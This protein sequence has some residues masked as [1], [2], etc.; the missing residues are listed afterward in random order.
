MRI[1]L[2]HTLRSIKAHI[3][4]PIVIV[5]TVTVATMLF[6]ASLS[7]KDLFYNFQLA[8]LSRVAQGADVSIEGGLFSGDR[9]DE[10][11][12]EKSSEV[13]Y[14]D[15]YLTSA[16]IISG[17]GDNRESTAI[18]IEATDLN[19]FL[20]RHKSSLHY[21]KGISQADYVYPEIWISRSL[22]EKL[23]C[24]VGGEAEIYVGFY[25]R[26]ETF[27]V[28]YI[29]ENEGF[30]ANSTVHNVLTDLSS[31]GDKGLYTEA[32][33]K[34]KESVDKEGF[35]DALSA[36]MDNAELEIGDAVDY[37]Y[38][39]RVVSDNENLL[40]I[41]LI[42]VVALV[43]FIL[44]GAYGVVAKN[45]AS[46]M[47][48]FKAAGASPLQ[49]FLILIT[50][51]IFYGLA[52]GIAG[53]VC[54]RFG[55]EIVVQSVIPGFSDA[56]NYKV[57]YYVLSVLL[58]IVI[59][60]AGSGVPVV[61]LVRRSVKRQENT[62]KTVK[63]IRPVFLIIPLLCVCA[64]VLGVIFAERMATLFTVCLVLSAVSA[65]ILAAP[66][67]MNGVST[68]FGLSKGACKLASVS[69]KRNFEAV[70]LSCMLGA[71]LMFAFITVNIVGI[72]IDAS[73]PPLTRFE[74]DY[75]VQAVSVADMGAV[76][77]M[78]NETPGIK[79]SVLIRY[80]TFDVTFNDRDTDLTVYVA[81]KAED[82]SCAF[83]LTAKEKE[84][85]DNEE[86]AAVLSYDLANRLG[87]KVGDG[88]E[89]TLNGQKY[90]FKIVAVN[91][92][93]TADDRVIFVNEAGFDYPLDSSVIFVN[94]DG[95]MPQKDLFAEVRGKLRENG[96][97]ILGFDE[98]AYATGVG[99]E[100]IAD[101]LRILQ[102]IVILVG[103]AGIANMTIAMT[104]TR[105][106]EFGVYRAAGLD[107]GKYFRLMLAESAEISVC[108]A[109]I[110]LVP[111]LAINTIIP[112]FAKLIDRYITAKFPW[113]IFVITGIAIVAYA[114][115]YCLIAAKNKMKNI[116][117]DIRGI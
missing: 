64:S 34:L 37:D 61:N 90:D 114:L 2:N 50:E 110:G 84:F 29:F 73:Q 23:G 16:G 47:L 44:F 25:G 76:N 18:V 27:T 74:A 15:K 46:E 35:T 22:A 85:F 83:A 52:G 82:F 57:Y 99:V 104:I 81:E 13:E 71:V 4:Q 28:T 65:V 59:S 86:S 26:N 87:K 103:I 42:F 66:Y 31:F 8:N 91:E 97:Y 36:H 111:A 102:V 113:E 78:L 40:E 70:S 72:I 43:I 117:I 51:V 108:G 75:T 93:K 5:L 69:I 96:C 106:R 107:N 109:I 1:I 12:S 56:V 98:W 11:I 80:E 77:D 49:L 17:E 48:V 7:L 6:F 112:S 62:V 45:R 95:N 54:G 67:V 94:A 21:Y 24:D 20:A 55:M 88:V 79:S 58:G 92:E 68:L 63:K 9:L 3:G 105:R 115:I 60:L 101:L 19:L 14:V 100:G 33:I 116:G 53:T 89:F 41:A 39:D 10:F 30:F 38:I 32:Y